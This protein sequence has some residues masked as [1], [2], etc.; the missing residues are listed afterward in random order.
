MTDHNKSI[1]PKD[2][3]QQTSEQKEVYQHKQPA[4]AGQPLSNVGVEKK[5]EVLTTASKEFDKTKKEEG[6]NEQNSEG[7]AGAFEGFE[8]QA[9]K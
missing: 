4:D 1:D 9:E 8:D 3:P 2:L 6:L 5:A 7:D